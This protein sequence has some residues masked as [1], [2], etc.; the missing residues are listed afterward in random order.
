MS[1]DEYEDCSIQ[2]LPD[3]GLWV[4]GDL[5]TN[6]GSNVN[7]NTNNNKE[8]IGGLDLLVFHEMFLLNKTKL[9]QETDETTT[10]KSPPA[11][12]WNSYESYEKKSSYALRR[13]SSISEDDEDYNHGVDCTSSC[14]FYQPDI[15][16]P[17]YICHQSGHI[18]HCTNEACRY[19]VRSRDQRSCILTGLVYALD[20]FL[21]PSTHDQFDFSNRTP[22]YPTMASLEKKRKALEKEKE[23]QAQL[24][25]TTITDES[26]SI[27]KP[28]TTRHKRRRSNHHHHHNRF[29]QSSSSTSSSSPSVSLLNNNLQ[30]RRTSS[31]STVTSSLQEICHARQHV[32]SILKLHHP[33]MNNIPL[34][35]FLGNI[36]MD[37]WKV[38]NKAPSYKQSKGSYK[39]EVH[40][41]AVL[42]NCIEGIFIEVNG[43]KSTFLP[44]L[45]EL[46][47]LLP[48]TTHL[49]KLG[50]ENKAYTSACR[51]L[52]SFA[53]E[54]YQ[55]VNCKID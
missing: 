21:V 12:S 55:D 14:E 27:K 13:S 40:C 5:Q 46:K 36:C 3:E 10:K 39:F 44:Y 45:F 26:Q 33:D 28:K 18:H 34:F 51:K 50:I 7:N 19:L 37:A 15:S 25:P 47:A 11:R 52:H 30:E 17:I 9:H 48:P 6:G 31:S 4:D 41:A 1:G 2:A 23:E 20:V 32:K 53:R 42:Y 35:D 16:I 22:I 49:P 29:Q 38:V 8:S 43:Q 54:V 24:T